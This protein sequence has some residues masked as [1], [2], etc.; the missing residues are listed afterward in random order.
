[1]NENSSF[2]IPKTFREYSHN[3]LVT[4]GEKKEKK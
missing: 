3:I 4:V 2:K 1:M